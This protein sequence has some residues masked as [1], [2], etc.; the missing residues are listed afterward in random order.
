[1]GEVVHISVSFLGVAGMG[2]L[3]WYQ[4]R[5]ANQRLN[6][7]MEENNQEVYATYVKSI[8]LR[9]INKIH[10]YVDF[11]V[12]F[13]ARIQQAYLAIPR[14]SLYD[15][16]KDEIESLRQF[17]SANTNSRAATIALG[18]QDRLH[19]L[20]AEIN[21]ICFDAIEASKVQTEQED[22]PQDNEQFQNT[23]IRL[24]KAVGE[25]QAALIEVEAGPAPTY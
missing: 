13:S 11:M 4:N 16:D 23:Y 6:K 14:S 8:K 22:R 1:M 24:L 3:A 20:L 7:T 2:I 18:E 19:P 25:L 17:S 12:G 21:I 9:Y 5:W 15:D 10:A